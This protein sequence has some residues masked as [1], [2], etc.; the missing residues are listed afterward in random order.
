MSVSSVINELYTDC[1]DGT[2]KK[3]KTN[4]Q[5]TASDDKIAALLA[6]IKKLQTEQLESDKSFKEYVQKSNMQQKK[7]EELSKKQIDDLTKENAQLKQ[8]LDAEQRKNLELTQKL[9]DATSAAKKSL[10]ENT[11]D[12]ARI[13][14]LESELERTNEE[15]EEAQQANKVAYDSIKEF[16]DAFAELTRQMQAS[17]ASIEANL[18]KQLK[19]A[20]KVLNSEAVF[21]SKR[22][23]AASL[24]GNYFTDLLKYA[25]E[26]GDGKLKSG[27]ETVRNANN[28]I[29]PRIIKTA[30]SISTYLPD[31]K[32]G[33]AMVSLAEKFRDYLRLYYD[34]K[35]MSKMTIEANT[36]QKIVDEDNFP[37]SLTVANN[38]IEQFP[39]NK[40]QADALVKVLRDIYLA[41]GLIVESVKLNKK[42]KDLDVNATIEIPLVR[43]ISDVIFYG[44]A[45]LSGK[46]DDYVAASKMKEQLISES[47]TFG[48]DLYVGLT[49]SKDRS[50]VEKFNPFKD[51][52]TSTPSAATAK[53]AN[54]KLKFNII[55]F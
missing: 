24:F 52:S 28:K 42:E 36:I 25:K 16:E 53:P 17:P 4:T 8:N 12:D 51:K 9:A 34:L 40:Q 39:N 15:L 43:L 3:K 50:L 23:K 30:N 26:F 2:K 46:A 48:L 37:V 54:A 7:I 27:I 44:A 1:F 29:F 35:S 33:S 10:K 41:L 18:S 14:E 11:V 45:Q 20:E 21:Q 49:D 38:F 55:K 13:A 6:N 31:K 19:V 47:K 22:Q 32:Y 5:P